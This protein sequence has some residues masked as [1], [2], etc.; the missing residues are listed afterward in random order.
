[1]PRKNVPLWREKFQRTLSRDRRNLKH[2]RAL[3][4]DVHVLWEC[5]IRDDE[6]LA[7]ELTQFLGT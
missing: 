1:M 4:W 7:A 3:G 2:L 5:L 6:C